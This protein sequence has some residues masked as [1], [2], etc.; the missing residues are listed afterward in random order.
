MNVAGLPARLVYAAIALPAG[1]AAGFYSCIFLLPRLAPYVAQ[2]DTDADGFGIF[3]IALGVGAA[4]AFTLS[5]LALTQPWKRHRKRRG[6]GWRI[7]VSCA[8]V[9]VVSAGLAA[10]GYS[11][12]YVL[13][14]AAWLAYT[15][16]YTFVRYGVVDDARRSSSSGY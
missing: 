5:L 1:G 16:A 9:V 10:D 12:V 13:M 6:R 4:L 11:I 8:I 2:L 7:A 15:M 14:F 3:K